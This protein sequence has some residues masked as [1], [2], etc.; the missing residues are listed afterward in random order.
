MNTKPTS[1]PDTIDKLRLIVR[2]EVKAAIKEEL[3]PVLL[4]VIKANN[5]TVLREHS[6]HQQ[7][8]AVQRPAPPIPRPSTTSY[9]AS[10]LEET[11]RQMAANLHMPENQEYRDLLTHTAPVMHESTYAQPPASITEEEIHHHSVS[12]MIASAGKA[13]KEEYVEIAEVPDFSSFMKKIN[14]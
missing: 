4:E 11:R 1:K 12:R 14:V 3:V 9:G 8:Q 10:L 13:S 6:T 5:S 7:P 2:Q